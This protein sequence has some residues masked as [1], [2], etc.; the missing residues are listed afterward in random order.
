MTQLTPYPTLHQW[1]LDR[2]EAMEH[3]DLIAKEAWKQQIMFVR[4]TL[5]HVVGRRKH[6]SVKVRSTHWSKST[7]LPVY[8]LHASW[9]GMEMRNNYHN[10]TVCVELRANCHLDLRDDQFMQKLAYPDYLDY[11]GMRRQYEPWTTTVDARR[12]AFACNS[13]YDLYALLAY[14]HCEIEGAMAA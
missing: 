4:D 9:G 13:N 12:F 14:I 8:L 5:I 6:T 10:W 2:L 11:G 7:E 3:S 1:F